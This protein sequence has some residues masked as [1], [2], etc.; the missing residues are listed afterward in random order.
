LTCREWNNVRVARRPEHRHITD[1][2]HL[3]RD[4]PWRDIERRTNTVLN[5][6]RRGPPNNIDGYPTSTLAGS[7]ADAELTSVEAAAHLRIL[8]HGDNDPVHTIRVRLIDMLEQT[9]MSRNAVIN[10][11]DQFDTLQTLGPD[12][13]TPGCESCARHPRA[14]DGQPTWMETLYRNRTDVNGRLSEPRWLCRWCY[15]W[16]IGT[17][18]LPT[19]DELATHHGGRNVRKPA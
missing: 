4:T 14:S 18:H 17:G 10:L 12:T 5:A 19:R 2:C 13:G 7:R 6:D 9:I 8:H 15:D 3:G 11:L 16:V 1:L